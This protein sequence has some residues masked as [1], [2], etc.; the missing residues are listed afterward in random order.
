[1]A[2]VPYWWVQPAVVCFGVLVAL[3]AIH[4]NRE[5]IRLRATLDIILASETNEN[6]L[7]FYHAFLKFRT[8]PAFR[9]SILQPASDEDRLQKILCL[10]YLNQFE[11]VAISI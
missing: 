11:L 5:S 1:M 3:S 9:T 6:Y 10:G 7:K 8:I 4:N 2:S